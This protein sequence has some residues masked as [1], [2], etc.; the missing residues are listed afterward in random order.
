MSKIE[1]K[2]ILVDVDETLLHWK[3]TY[4]NFLVSSDLRPESGSKPYSDIDY[5]LKVS[6]NEILDLLNKFHDSESYSSL[7]PYKDALEVVRQLHED[8]WKFVAITAVDPDEN[9]VK[10]RWKNLCDCFGNAFVDLHCTGHEV[11]DRSNKKRYLNKYEPTW[12]IED[13][14]KHAEAGYEVGHR[15]ILLNRQYNTQYEHHGIIRVDDWYEIYDI[16]QEYE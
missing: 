4:S 12:W 15:S 10:A 1:N 14:F 9:T 5:W 11:G 2:I 7:P 13:T 3:G 8:G 16:I 6:K